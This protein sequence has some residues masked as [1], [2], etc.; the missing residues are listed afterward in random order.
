MLNE[1]VVKFALE[2]FLAVFIVAVVVE[3]FASVLLV[4]ALGAIVGS[5]FLPV[6][7]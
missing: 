1:L 5:A 2:M 3:F 6:L 4:L 7:V